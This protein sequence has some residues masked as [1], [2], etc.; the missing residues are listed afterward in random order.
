MSRIKPYKYINPNLIT[1]MKAGKKIDGEKGG[2]TIIAAGKKITGPAAEGAGAVKMGRVTLLG[3]N[4]IG[5]TV[6]AIGNANAAFFKTIKTENK[7][8]T[9]QAEIKKRRLQRAKDQ[10]NEDRIEAG[11]TKP[12]KNA[13]NKD[14]KKKEKKLTWLEKLFGPFKGIIEFALRTMITQGLL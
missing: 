11:T 1:G 3:L 14:I 10:A 4:R 12:I 13:L 9:Q 5:S 6:E 7:F 8:I 2:A